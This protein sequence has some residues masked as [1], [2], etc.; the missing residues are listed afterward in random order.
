MAEF[1]SIKGQITIIGAEGAHTFE[2]QGAKPP[3]QLKEIPKYAG[4]C[5]ARSLLGA[6]ESEVL[7]LRAKVKELQTKLDEVI[8]AGKKKDK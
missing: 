3:S 8:V 7:E 2:F 5:I 4:E 1:K 6:D